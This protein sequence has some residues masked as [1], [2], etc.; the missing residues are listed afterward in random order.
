MSRGPFLVAAALFLHL[1]LQH[2][3]L[4]N[5]AHTRQR[6]NSLFILPHSTFMRGGLRAQHSRVHERRSRIKNTR[7]SGIYACG[8]PFGY[9]ADF[10]GCPA[11][12][13]L[14]FSPDLKNKRRAV[15]QAAR[16]NAPYFFPAFTHSPKNTRELSAAACTPNI[17]SG[18][19]DRHRPLLETQRCRSKRL[20]A[21][22]AG[23]KKLT[24]GAPLF[25]K[26]GNNPYR[27]LAI[28]TASACPTKSLLR[29]R[30]SK[31]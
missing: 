28:F 18:F 17:V 27:R 10:C 8:C 16:L 13:I 15:I 3:H 5:D 2:Q 7:V 25:L 29:F 24:A 26:F 20:T 19:G 22:T 30:S 12:G 4:K 1:V 11:G 6:L 21:T 31:L 14:M 23:Q 9:A